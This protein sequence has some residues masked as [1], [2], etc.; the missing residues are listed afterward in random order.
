M[1]IGDDVTKFGDKDPVEPEPVE[2][3]WVKEME[4]FFLT[5]VCGGFLATCLGL[6]SAIRLF[7]L[8]LLFVCEVF[9]LLFQQH[10]SQVVSVSVRQSVFL[11]CWHV[12]G[13]RHFPSQEGFHSRKAVA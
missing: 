9:Q 11:V 7:F 13:Q 8:T 3:I 12:I 5:L 2:P 1:F 4:T 6:D 10:S